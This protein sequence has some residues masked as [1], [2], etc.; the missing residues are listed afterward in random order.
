MTQPFTLPT[1][2][3]QVSLP[4]VLPPLVITAFTRPDLLIHVLNAIR[5][6]TLKPQQIIAYI[7]GARSAADE[8]LIA[9]C[10]DQLDQLAHEIPVKIVTRSEN[11]GCDQNVILAFTEVLNEYES[12]VYLEDDDVPNP[13]FFDR[14]CR[15]L[16]AYRDHKK[17]FSVSAYANFPNSLNNA[18]KN[19]FIVSNRVFSWG[20]GIWADRW[21][22]S[23]LVN[24]PLQ[25]N[26]F[27]SFYN[28][29]TTIQTTL[30]LINQFWLEKNNKTDWMITATIT[31]LHQQKVHIIP[32][33]SFVK[34]IGFGHIQSKTYRGKE[35][36]W[37]N[38]RYDALA[39]PDQLPSST[40]LVDSLSKPLDGPS[41]THFLAK[42]KGL[43]LSPKA[44]WA[45]LT[46]FHDINSSIALLTLFVNRLPLLLRRWRSGLPV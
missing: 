26:P 7:D 14:M 33:T 44:A 39:E 4:K 8:P 46:K 1:S 15:L 32:T 36:D 3:N 25:Y 42:Q 17:V 16:E 24:H 35:Q 43:W 5:Q 10:I 41:L 6:Q 22:E 13:C 29:P 38:A 23:D 11:L 30:T 45:F 40:E 28:I 21:Q 18:I 19:D 20:F 2:L 31:A 37:V 9:Q 12:L 27:G 34:N